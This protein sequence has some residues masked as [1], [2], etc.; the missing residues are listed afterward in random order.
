[1]SSSVTSDPVVDADPA[2][3]ARI[4]ALNVYGRK[5]RYLS[6]SWGTSHFKETFGLALKMCSDEVDTSTGFTI[7]WHP[8]KDHLACTY[9]TLLGNDLKFFRD[10]PLAG[11]LAD[12]LMEELHVIAMSRAV[13]DLK[14]EEDAALLLRA[15]SRL[16][17]MVQAAVYAKCRPAP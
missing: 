4:V 7:S 5:G 8:S 2:A 10:L 9:H 14:A 16:D 1:M 6:E 12:V 13:V 17:M 15:K 3:V 11:A